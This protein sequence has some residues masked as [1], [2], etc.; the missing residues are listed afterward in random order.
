MAMNGF[1]WD[2]MDEIRKLWIYAPV[3]AQLTSFGRSTET[4]TASFLSHMR[5]DK[6]EK[7]LAWS[8]FGSGKVEANCGEAKRRRGLKAPSTIEQS[9]GGQE[10]EHWNL[11]E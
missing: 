3:S 7:R 11:P 1:V 4:R 5:R 2:S 6:K 10:A 9:E 8:L